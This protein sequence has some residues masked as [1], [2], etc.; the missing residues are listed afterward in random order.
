M[1]ESLEKLQSLGTVLLCINGIGV[2]ISL[3]MSILLFFNREVRLGLGGAHSA[4][5]FFLSIFY[6]SYFPFIYFGF[7]GTQLH[8]KFLL[9]LCLCGTCVKIILVL[10]ITTREVASLVFEVNIVEVNQTAVHCASENF[11]ETPECLRVLRALADTVFAFWKMYFDEANLPGSNGI[12]AFNLLDT[13]QK[14]RS[15]CGLLPPESC[16][17]LSTDNELNET[18]GLQCNT[19]MFRYKDCEET[20]SCMYFLPIGTCHGFNYRKGC[21]IDIEVFLSQNILGQ[22]NILRRLLILSVFTGCS[23]L[24]LILRRKTTDIIVEFKHAIKLS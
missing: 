14:E 12:M 2:I 9:F 7:K 6:S 10:L 19:D 24:F 8:N 17:I 3:F 4:R 5:F 11:T 1:I 20:S 15:C 23:I 21:M 22:I 16:R 18:L 13:I